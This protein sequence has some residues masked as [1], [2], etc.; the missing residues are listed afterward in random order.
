MNNQH[1]QMQ[2]MSY[3]LGLNTL[4]E[5]L[6]SAEKAQDEKEIARVTLA[7]EKL[8]AKNEQ[9]TNEEKIWLH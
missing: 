5:A 9:F 6:E 7:L 2:L 1:R 8:I 4:S 3:Q